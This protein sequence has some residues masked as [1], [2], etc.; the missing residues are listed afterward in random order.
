MSANNFQLL[1]AVK[2]DQFGTQLPEKDHFTFC[3][4][5]YQNIWSF[6]NVLCE[7]R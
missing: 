6:W 5:R 4:I 1:L 2:M 3:R 7:I